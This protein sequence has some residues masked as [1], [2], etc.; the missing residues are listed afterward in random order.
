VVPGKAPAERKNNN[1]KKCMLK[2][3]AID[4]APEVISTVKLFLTKNQMR[5][6]TQVVG[7]PQKQ[8]LIAKTTNSLQMMFC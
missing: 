7:T 3:N 2:K 8:K 1:K 5:A 4:V 6:Q